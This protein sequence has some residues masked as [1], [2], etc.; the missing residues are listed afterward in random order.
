MEEIKEQLESEDA[1]NGLQP[2]SRSSASAAVV[3]VK[4]RAEAINQKI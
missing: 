1:Q 2:Q 3:G 4:P